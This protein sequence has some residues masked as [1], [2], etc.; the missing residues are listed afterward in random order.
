MLAQAKR[1]FVILGGSG[2][3]AQACADFRAFAEA[4]NLPVGTAFRRQDLY[5]NRLANYV[6]DVGIGINP[7]L[8]ERVKAADLLLAIGTR[9]DEMTTGGYTL[10]DVP[11]PK[12][13]FV[14]VHPGAEELGRVYEA[15]LL[16]NSGMPEFA[17]G[18]RKLRRWTS[19]AW[20]DWTKA[21][22]SGVRGVAQA[23]A[24]RRA[25]ST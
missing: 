2:W 20:S 16:I 25:A 6:G 14:H 3:N 4:N 8:A 24:R 11:R 19:S 23:G 18:A 13:K 12:Q 15:D 17:A 7:A 10:I 9:L 22:R 21:A 1:P 5:D